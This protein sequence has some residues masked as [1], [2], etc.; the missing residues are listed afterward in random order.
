[1]PE[2]KT[3]WTLDSTDGDDPNHAVFMRIQIAESMSDETHLQLLDRVLGAKFFDVVRTQQQLGY[4]VQMGASI[5][6][7]FSYLLAI[8]QTEFHPDYARSRIEAFLDDHF[9]FVLNELTDEEFQTCRKGLIA[10]L[11]QKPK[12][13]SEEMDR[14]TRRFLNR[15]FDFGRRQRVIDFL[16]TSATLTSLRAF[17]TDTLQHAPRFFSQIK[18]V[19]DK[20]DKPLPEGRT[21]PEDPKELRHWRDHQETVRS[22]HDSATWI[23]LNS[24]VDVVP[25]KL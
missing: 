4:I 10:S 17:L 13:L 20:P 6:A 9:A 1:M 5:G 11:R 25:A 23:A 15:T 14:Y 22:F 12:N 19:L 24:S 2:G 3:V 7:K 16:E 21:I 8:V 18:K